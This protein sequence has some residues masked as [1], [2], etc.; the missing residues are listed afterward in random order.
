[1]I[2]SK[3]ALVVAAKEF[4]LV[5]FLPLIAA[6]CMDSA[7]EIEKELRTMP[8]EQ[9]Y[10]HFK[11]LSAKDQVDVYVY[12]LNVSRPVSSRYEFLLQD[13]PRDVAELLVDA[14]NATD[15]YMVSVSILS[16]LE[17]M[18]ESSRGSVNQRAMRAA[19]RR[20]KA[21]AP[22]ADDDLC[23]QYGRALVG[24]VGH[25]SQVAVRRNQ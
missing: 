20:C 23:A 17:K 19:V 14:A 10:A 1:M 7:C 11:A 8:E 6:C 4:W 3:M 25:S 18:P 13:G 12:E 16:T 5:T 2:C 21:L 15:S 24:S 22:K 9:A